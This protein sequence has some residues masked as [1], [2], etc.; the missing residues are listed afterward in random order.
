MGILC[1]RKR[2]RE[3]P[4]H[5]AREALGIQFFWDDVSVWGE[6]WACFLET[7]FV[8]ALS[9]CFGSPWIPL[10]ISVKSQGVEIAGL[11]SRTGLIMG[12]FFRGDC[13]WLGLLSVLVRG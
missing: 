3:T 10:G 12:D 9:D 7:G 13:R 11:D 6:L 2:L 8:I 4:S 1:F 5:A